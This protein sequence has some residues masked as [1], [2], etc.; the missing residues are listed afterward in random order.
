MKICEIYS[1]L[2]NSM[3][4]R[5]KFFPH[6]ILSKE[7]SNNVFSQFESFFMSYLKDQL[8]SAGKKMKESLK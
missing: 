4:K 2:M 6:F 1:S 3:I 5:Q 7:L 8:W